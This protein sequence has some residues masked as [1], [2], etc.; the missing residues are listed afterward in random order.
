MS[1]RK[2]P[3]A[4]FGLISE[5]QKV[6][7]NYSNDSYEMGIGD[8]AAIRRGHDNEKLILTTD[9]SVEN[10]HFSLKTMSL[11]EAAYRA[12]VSN[13]S[14]CAA[15]G[16]FP[17]SALIQL[18]FPR[19]DGNLKEKILDVYKGFS[20]ACSRWKF[21][22]VGG[23]LSGADQWVMGITLLGKVSDNR[24]ILK[25]VG[26]RDGDK[27]WV[28]GFPGRS[29][30][31]FEVLQKWGRDGV[32]PP[33]LGLVQNHIAP[34]PRIE[35]AIALAANPEVHALMDLSDGLSKDCRTLCYENKLGVV[36]NVDT[37]RIPDAMVQ[38]SA[39]TGI[40]VYDWFLHGGEDYELLFS[41]SAHF[42]PSSINP[43]Y[44]GGFHC[45][46]YFTSSLEG[47]FLE[48]NGN[49]SEVAAQSWD[50][51]GSL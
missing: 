27:V 5:L 15:M 22:V 6:L 4:E 2:Y 9:I 37:S 23:D 13:I 11:Q 24:R 18:A 35:A 14:D 48:Q 49:I 41:A 19:S 7:N 16:A 33:Y 31:G 44:S 40:S 50:H 20:Q 30:A 39:E 8:D 3:S 51:V 32:P 34:V 28:S 17:D 47:L 10:V 12:M 21:P 45:I 38:L 43:E 25:R 26:A 46:G 29:A 42:D 36:L 1:E